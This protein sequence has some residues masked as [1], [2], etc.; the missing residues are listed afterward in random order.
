MAF[1]SGLSIAHF[2]YVLVVCGV[3]NKFFIRGGG[4]ENRES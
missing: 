4:D 2:L 1:L 3:W